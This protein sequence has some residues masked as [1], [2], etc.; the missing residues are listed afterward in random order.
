M[1]T[2]PPRLSVSPG[3]SPTIGVRNW[4][5]GIWAGGTTTRI[6]I[7]DTMKGV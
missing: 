1:V 3:N 7:A 5:N 2:R 4:E 6:E